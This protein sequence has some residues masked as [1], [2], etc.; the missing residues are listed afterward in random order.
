MATLLHLEGAQ[1]LHKIYPALDPREH[2]WRLFYALPRLRAWIE[3]TLPTLESSWKIEESP[4]EQLDALI[5]VFCSGQPL[6]YGQQFKPLRHIR[7]GIWELKTADL[8][9]FGWFHTKD[10]F[11]GSG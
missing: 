3:R 10:C 4:V 9:V 11:I 1:L 5:Y 8:R 2:E 7:D 6:A